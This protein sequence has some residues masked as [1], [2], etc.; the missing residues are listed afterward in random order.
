ISKGSF[1]SLNESTDYLEIHH[2]VIENQTYINSNW[3]GSHEYCEMQTYL[4]VYINA[5]STPNKHLFWGN[6]IH[7]YLASFFSLPGLETIV[8]T[9]GLLKSTIQDA[10]KQACYQNWTY[11]VV[12]GKDMEAIQQEFADNFLENEITFIKRDYRKNREIYG[13]FAYICE[14]FVQ[15]RFLG[16]QG[17]IDRMVHNFPFSHY[18]LYETKTGTSLRS[19]QSAAFY[20]SL[21]YVSIL[22]E[23]TSAECDNIII[24]H[25]RLPVEERLHSYSYETAEMLKVLRIRN[26]I[27]RMLIGIQPESPSGFPCLRCGAKKVCDFYVYRQKI[28]ENST[29]ILKKNTFDVFFEED[30]VNRQLFHELNAY[31]TWFYYFLDQELFQNTKTMNNILS[32]ISEREERGNGIGNLVYDP[33]N[34][35]VEK[36]ETNRDGESE[37]NKKLYRFIKTDDKSIQNTRLRDGDYIVLSAQVQ[38]SLLI[39]KWTGRIKKINPKEIFIEFS[40][41]NEDFEID[42]PSKLFR[43]DLTTSNYMVRLQKRAIDTLI[44]ESCLFPKSSTRKLRDLLLFR[45]MPRIDNTKTTEITL[46]GS[47]FDSSQQHAILT[48]LGS[49]DMTLIQGPP[50]TG[51]T[52]IIVEI[53]AQLVKI[54]KESLPQENLTDS[55]LSS[56]SEGGFSSRPVLISSYTNKALDNILLKLITNHPKIRIVRLGN[57]SNIENPIILS[58]SLENICKEEILY[59]SSKQE[60][61]INPLKAR[62]ILDKV[63]VI[64]TT[65]TTAGSMLL[66]NIHFDTVILDEAGQ[67]VEGSALIPLLKGNRFILVGDHQQLPP[68]TLESSNFTSVGPLSPILSPCEPFLKKLKFDPTKGM[69]VSIFERLV[70]KYHSSKSYVLLS[71]QYRM[72]RVICQFISDHFYDGLLIPGDFEGKSIGDQTFNEFLDDY[73]L[74]NFSDDLEDPH[75]PWAF[76]Y[77]PARPLIFLNTIKLN[78]Q[79]SSEYLHTKTLESIFNETEIQVVKKLLRTLFHGIVKRVVPVN[80]LIELFAKIGIISGYRAQNQKIAAEINHLFATIIFQAPPYCNLSFSEQQRI[81]NALV[82]DTVDRFQGQERELIIYSFVDSNSRFTLHHLSLEIRRLNVA[83]SRA[84]KKIIL[85]GHSPTLAQITPRDL[86][87]DQKVKKLHDDLITYVRK[88]E[89]YLALPPHQMVN[90]PE[91]KE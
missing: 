40:N 14:K 4:S 70:Q 83:I 13:S 63:D 41:L 2:V 77:S 12:L 33:R 23:L 22:R 48:A 24:E 58:K 73:H 60:T 91:E 61:V 45:K 31:F 50:G 20:Q 49:K 56:I 88:H 90:P 52:T 64:A 46:N 27:W 57:I 79:D 28:L 26:D 25:P 55:V 36:G 85:I 17:R 76:A 34:I 15:S 66:H 86:P 59:L 65:T 42:S 78:P 84:K 89:G 30:Q 53:I 80:Q 39:E 16:M 75:S 37:D 9:E 18:L 44:R 11:F 8:D 29:V 71:K 3:I 10:F 21:A 43:L 81:Q 69:K 7:D 19:S 1:K 47:W 5:A 62:L 72:N 54:Q 51:K 32:P 68:I 35:S 74:V 67:I 6:L 82:I 87:Q 38:H